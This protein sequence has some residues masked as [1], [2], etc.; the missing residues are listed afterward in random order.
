MSACSN[1]AVVLDP[2][3]LSRD[4]DLWVFNDDLQ[5]LAD[6]REEAW[7]FRQY[8]GN[9]SEIAQEIDSRIQFDKGDNRP[10]RIYSQVCEGRLFSRLTPEHIR[11]IYFGG[12]NK[13]E[14][15]HWALELESMVK[16]ARTTGP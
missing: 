8:A 2:E 14:G 7:W 4:Q 15:M 10:Q 13:D 5:N 11:R 16:R 6:K 9:M 12:K 3:K 1:V